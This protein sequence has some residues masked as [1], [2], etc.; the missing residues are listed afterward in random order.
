MQYL[1]EMIIDAIQENDLDELKNIIK[2][3]PKL[4]LD[5]NLQEPLYEASEINN[6]EMV[7]YLLTHKEVFV[8]FKSPIHISA[9]EDNIEI[10][11]FYFESF[12]INLNEKEDLLLI[13]TAFR[14]GSFKAALY[15]FSMDFYKN[16]LSK[17]GEGYK[18][19]E[20]ELRRLEKLSNF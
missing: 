7:K 18:K 9:I 13:R 12:D 14:S 6:L 2:E 19:I 5:F 4:K 8:E 1:E 17:I 10:L 20:T 15:L 3:N 16:N 11:K